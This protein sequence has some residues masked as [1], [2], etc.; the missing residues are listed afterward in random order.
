MK[1]T[2]AE[3]NCGKPVLR[4]VTLS[5][6]ID[7]QLVAYANISGRKMDR[8]LRLKSLFLRA[9]KKRGLAGLGCEPKP[10]ANHE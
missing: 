4:R 7:A 6:N 5:A 8:T 2:F 3:L 10:V 1:V 9:I